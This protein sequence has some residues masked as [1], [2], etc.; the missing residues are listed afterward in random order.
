MTKGSQDPD[1]EDGGLDSS[2]CVSLR[3]SHLQV[4]SLSKLGEWNLWSP[5]IKTAFL[6]A[7]GLS[8]DVFSRALQSNGSPRLHA[9]FGNWKFQR[10]V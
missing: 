3:A 10:K 4:I 2:G 5:L 9:A 6:R 7:D 1:L 8:R